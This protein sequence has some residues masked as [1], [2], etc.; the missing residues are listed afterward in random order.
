MIVEK[1]YK[2][3]RRWKNNNGEWRYEYPKGYNKKKHVTEF[4]IPIDMLLFH[5]SL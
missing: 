3:I 4:M 1:A 2:Y 5:Y